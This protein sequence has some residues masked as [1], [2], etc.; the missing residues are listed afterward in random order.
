MVSCSIIGFSF[1]LCDV[2]EEQRCAGIGSL[3]HKHND[4]YI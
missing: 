3:T 1:H 2:L 4:P